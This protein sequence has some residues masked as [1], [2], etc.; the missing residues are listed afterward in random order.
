MARMVNNG[1]AASLP[2]TVRRIGQ[3][4][5]SRHS[6]WALRHGLVLLSG[7]FAKVFQ[8]E[9]YPFRSVVSGAI[10]H[11]VALL[12]GLNVS[13]PSGTSPVRVQPLHWLGARVVPW[14][15]PSRKAAT[16]LW[17]NPCP[18]RREAAPG[19]AFARWGERRNTPVHG[20]LTGKTFT[21]WSGE[22]VPAWRLGRWSGASLQAAFTLPSV[23]R[24]TASRCSG[25]RSRGAAATGPACRDA[26]KPPSCTP[27]FLLLG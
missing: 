24:P 9:R 19:L 2:R 27:G 16:A 1:V 8:Q 22:T 10:H 7:D 18:N 14:Q 5:P 12:Q 13:F 21:C 6:T 4:F 17:L 25:A 26:L 11:G 15:A 20:G 23:Q 3:P